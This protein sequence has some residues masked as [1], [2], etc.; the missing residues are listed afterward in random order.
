M[1]ARTNANRTFNLAT[2]GLL[3]LLGLTFL[4]Q[5]LTGLDL[6]D[7][8][9][10]ALFILLFAGGFLSNVWKIYQAEGRL[11]LAARSPLIG[12]LTL[13]LMAVVFFFNLGW[14]LVWPL[15]L[16]IIGMSALVAR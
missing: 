13:S 15:F 11:T 3:I 4:T 1:H 9:W 16:I 14:G 2:G 12:G 7:W 6:W 10:W 5:N 8:N